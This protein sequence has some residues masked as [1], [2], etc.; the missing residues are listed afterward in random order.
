MNGGYFSNLSNFIM[1]RPQIKVWTHG[2]THQRC[3]YMMGTTRVLCNARGYAGYEK[4]ADDFDPN[5]S[6]E[7]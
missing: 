3:D 2:H 5:F 7:V 6:F 1:D 4:S